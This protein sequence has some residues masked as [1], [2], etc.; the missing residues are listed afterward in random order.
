LLATI[1]GGTICALLLGAF[2]A[3]LAE[4][5]VLAFFLALVL[6][7]GES[8]AIQSMTVTIQALR[9]RSTQRAK[10]HHALRREA[11]TAALLGLFCGVAVGAIAYVWKGES[12]PAVTIGLGI[13]GAVLAACA[14]GLSI[15]WAFHARRIDLKIAV[16][17]LVLACTDV[18]TVAVYLLTAALFLK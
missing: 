15:P 9:A 14:I 8:V 17:P 4:S 18:C 16:G 7:L 2:E 1:T 11:L 3:T 6:G 13:C 12:R 10:Y 5:L